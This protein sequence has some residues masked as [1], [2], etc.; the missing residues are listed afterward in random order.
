MSIPTL[1]PHW[2]IEKHG[3]EDTT[4]RTQHLFNIPGWRHGRSF[5]P[6]HSQVLIV[7]CTYCE[8]HWTK[9]YAKWC[10]LN[11]ERAPGEGLK[12]KCRIVL[13]G[14]RGPGGPACDWHYI[15]LNSYVVFH[16]VSVWGEYQQNKTEGFSYFDL[17]SIVNEGDH[18]FLWMRR[19]RGEVRGQNEWIG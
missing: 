18:Y 10:F 5:Q 14:S 2:N 11:A 12:C 8:S 13:C 6:T 9:A 7:E 4:I 3:N 19:G 1:H 16:L 17:W 15:T